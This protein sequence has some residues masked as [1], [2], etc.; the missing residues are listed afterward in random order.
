M[1]LPRGLGDEIAGEQVAQARQMQRDAARGVAPDV[2]HDGS[3]G[4]VEHVAVRGFVI[5][6]ARRGRRHRPRHRRVQ[7]LFGCGERRPWPGLGATDE[8][9][10]GSPGHDG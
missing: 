2:Q 7:C 1:T 4:E 3:A 10:V 9:R 8:R 5:N 6:T